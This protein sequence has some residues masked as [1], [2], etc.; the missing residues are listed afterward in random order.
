MSLPG[1]AKLFGALRRVA[2]PSQPREPPLR[3]SAVC[4]RLVAA[5]QPLLM[6]HGF[7]RFDGRCA[8]RHGEPWTDVLE[9][10]FFP[11]P[12]GMAFTP[13]LKAGRYLNAVPDYTLAG[14]VKQSEGRFYPIPELCHFRKEVFVPGVRGTRA[15]LIGADGEGLEACVAQ[16]AT[17]VRT[18]VLP[19][20]AWLD[21]LQTVAALLQ[22]GQVDVEGRSTD[23]LLRGCWGY[24]NYFSQHVVAGFVALQLGRPEQA[25]AL[26]APVLEYGGVLGRGRQVF[27]LAPASL[28][29]I[30]AARDAA[31]RMV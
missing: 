17:A 11:P 20:L 21:D 23:Q 15:W 27:P 25:A 6:E 2:A 1:L 29:A 22:S 4:K 26:L 18:V 31:L 7:S 19:W 28:Q 14:V 24:A 10:Q 5:L 12:V 16:A 3:R 30:A 13:S 8:W 9:I